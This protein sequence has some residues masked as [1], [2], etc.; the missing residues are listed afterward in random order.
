[1]EVTVQITDPAELVGHLAGT[2]VSAE[3]DRD[4]NGVHL[5]FDDGRVVILTGVLLAFIGRLDG[6]TLQ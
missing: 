6:R 4:S 1:L 5:F 2:I 3:V